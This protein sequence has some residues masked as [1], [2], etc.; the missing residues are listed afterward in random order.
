MKRDLKTGEILYRWQTTE[1]ENE[2]G[3]SLPQKQLE[4]HFPPQP[5][6]TM[7]IVKFNKWK[8]KHGAILYGM[9]R[10]VQDQVEMR[11]KNDDRFFV[12]EKELARELTLF[13]YRTSTSVTNIQKPI[14]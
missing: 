12:K 10:F 9:I 8:K 7:A 11:L 4:Q 2:E 5:E 14:H 13:A 3:E 6:S 1:A